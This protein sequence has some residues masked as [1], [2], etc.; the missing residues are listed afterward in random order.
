MRQSVV[1]LSEVSAL[2]SVWTLAAGAPDQRMY[3]ESW[4]LCVRK[5]E[6]GPSGLKGLQCKAFLISGGVR[7]IAR[8]FSRSFVFLMQSIRYL[9]LP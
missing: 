9:V 7:I 2:W 3:D 8:G 1:R 4:V 5:G 6:C